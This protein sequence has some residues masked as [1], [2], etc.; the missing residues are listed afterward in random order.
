MAEQAYTLRQAADL[1]GKSVDTLRRY[2][3]DGK[4]P[5]AGPIPGDR[6]RTIYIPSAALVAAG[7][8]AADALA[9]GEP[10]AVIARRAAERQRDSEHDELVALRALK[11]TW[12]TERQL[13]ENELRHAHKLNLALA[14]RGNGRAA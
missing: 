6:T 8:I 5:G 3:R 1:T 9:A 13:L 11:A 2:N 14:A 7:L 12:A 4:L 10:E